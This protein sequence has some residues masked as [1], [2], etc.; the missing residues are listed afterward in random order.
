ME[1]EAS[2][3]RPPR[4]IFSFKMTCLGWVYIIVWVQEIWGPNNPLMAFTFELKIGPKLE[5]LFLKWGG[6]MSH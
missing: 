6:V 1:Y 5:D 3:C 4:H 2:T